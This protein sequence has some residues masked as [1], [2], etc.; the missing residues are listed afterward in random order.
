[1]GVDAVAVD[2]EIGLGRRRRAK[3]SGRDAARHERI[4]FSSIHSTKVPGS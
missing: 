3:G 2:A 4:E 1:M